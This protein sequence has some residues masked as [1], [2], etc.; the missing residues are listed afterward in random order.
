M[1]TPRAALP[2]YARP[3]TAAAQHNLWSAIRALAGPDLPETL[4]DPESLWDH[5]LCPD[6]AFS[7]CCGL[8]FRARLHGHVQ[9]IGTPDYGLPGCPPGHYASTFIMRRDTAGTDPAA[10]AGLT[11][12]YNSRNSQSGWAAAQNHMRDL[13]LPRFESILSTGGHRASIAAVAGG[14]ADIACIDMQ[15]WRMATA[16]DAETAA[17][18]EVGHTAPTP[19]LPFVTG[20]AGD[21]AALRHAARAAIDA[22]PARDRAVLPITA[23]VDI[24]AEA[25]LAVPTPPTY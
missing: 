22:M 18:T 17:L 13:G 12:A 1:T 15:T 2:M 6:L 19:G 11:L 23:L 3:E 16:W 20:P 8:P 7:Q 24:P 10:W 4:E 5:W 14:A 9:L 21:A 25:Y